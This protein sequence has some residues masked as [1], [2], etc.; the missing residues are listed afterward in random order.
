MFGLSFVVAV[1]RCGFVLIHVGMR[2]TA[3]PSSLLIRKFDFVK[4][5]GIK[6]S[7][8]WNQLLP[9][10]RNTKNVFDTSISVVSVTSMRSHKELL[11]NCFQ[12]TWQE[13]LVHSVSV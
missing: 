2:R 8:Y 9:P 11:Y 1:H 10:S 6:L 12:I 7:N 3:T 5:S 13:E 4:G